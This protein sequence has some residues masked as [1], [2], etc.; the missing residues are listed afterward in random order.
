MA[1][2]AAHSEEG[3][4]DHLRW[5][6]LSLPRHISQTPYTPEVYEALWSTYLGTGALPHS[7]ELL[8]SPNSRTTG[9]YG[10]TYP[11][12]ASHDTPAYYEEELVTDNEWLGTDALRRWAEGSGQ[13]ALLGDGQQ[14]EDLGNRSNYDDAHFYDAAGPLTTRKK[15]P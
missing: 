11:H 1:Q 4:N 14:L 3:G 8:L 10:E 6:Q 12:S 13:G 7:D 5:S 9:P 2:I 15:A